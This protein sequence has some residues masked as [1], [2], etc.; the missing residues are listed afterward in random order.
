MLDAHPNNETV[1]NKILV[2]FLVVLGICVI[3]ESGYR[4]GR[5][6]RQ[7]EHAQAAQIAPTSKATI[8]EPHGA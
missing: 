8:A 5:Y 6:L 3:A 1:M 7:S 2:G 4:L